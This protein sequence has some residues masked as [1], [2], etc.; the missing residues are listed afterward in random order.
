[1]VDVRAG[2][3]P[4]ELFRRFQPAFVGSMVMNFDLQLEALLAEGI[5]GARQ[6]EAATG[7]SLRDLGASGIVLFGAGNLGQRALAGLRAVGI[8]PLCFVD[9]NQL[10]WARIM[11]E[12]RS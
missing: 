6:R 10:V 3:E 4:L 5:D 2:K 1:M 11:K 12:F 9:N 8:E 7:D